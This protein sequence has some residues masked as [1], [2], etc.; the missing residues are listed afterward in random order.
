[1]LLW[2]RNERYSTVGHVLLEPVKVSA[3]FRVSYDGVRYN[4]LFIA[5]GMMSTSKV[6]KKYNIQHLCVS[7]AVDA[8]LKVTFFYE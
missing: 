7:F 6:F 1:M 2:N 5:T 3:G 8:E 4:E